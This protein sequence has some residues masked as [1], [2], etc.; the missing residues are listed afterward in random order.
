MPT[1]AT[2]MIFFI[3]ILYNLSPQEA[4]TGCDERLYKIIKKFQLRLQAYLKI[5]V[6]FIDRLCGLLVR[7]LGYS[8]GGLGS[9]PGTTKKSSGSGTESTQ[10]REYN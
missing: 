3:I 10:P 6:H 9:I 8:S 4:E 2:E 5:V 1:I 7:V